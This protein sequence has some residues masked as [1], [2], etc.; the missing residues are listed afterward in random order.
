MSK[1]MSITRHVGERTGTHLAL[2]AHSTLLDKRG[3]DVCL[4]QNEH[5]NN[6]NGDASPTLGSWVKPLTS[7]SLTSAGEFRAVALA[8]LTN[9]SLMMLTVNSLVSKMF[10]RVSLGR[11]EGKLNEMLTKGGLWDTCGGTWPSQE[12]DKIK[13]RHAPTRSSCIE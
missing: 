1:A 12:G 13:G 5:R 6:G 8:A 10:S 2:K 4:N 9:G 7:H 11:L 3:S